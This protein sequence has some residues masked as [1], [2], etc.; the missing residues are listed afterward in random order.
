LDVIISLK[1]AISWLPAIVYLVACYDE[2][3]G[4]TPEEKVNERGIDYA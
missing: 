2:K 3:N 1:S 4:K